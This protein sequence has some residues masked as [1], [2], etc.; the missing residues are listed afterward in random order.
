[1]GATGALGAAPGGVTGGVMGG[2][3]SAPAPGS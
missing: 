1:M 2:A 3:S